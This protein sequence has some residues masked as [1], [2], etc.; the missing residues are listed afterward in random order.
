MLGIIQIKAVDLGCIIRIYHLCLLEE[1]DACRHAKI[2]PD[3][4]CTAVH[5][6]SP[7]TGSA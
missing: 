1:L 2:N 4:Q 6:S 7:T 3:M 5:Q